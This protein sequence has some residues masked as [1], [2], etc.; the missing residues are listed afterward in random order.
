M[1]NDG[2]EFVENNWLDDKLGEYLIAPVDYDHGFV[3]KTVNE[4]LI[5]YIKE[6]VDRDIIVHEIYNVCR[7]VS[8]EIEL[9]SARQEV[10]DKI[11]PIDSFNAWNLSI[12][13]GPTTKQ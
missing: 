3:V 13:C 4:D 2:N 1:P 5:F 6:R 10:M 7:H 8:T 11:D 9:M 12:V